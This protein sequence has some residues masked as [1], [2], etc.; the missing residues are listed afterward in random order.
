LEFFKIRNKPLAPFVANRI[1]QTQAALE[2]GANDPLISTEIIAKCDSQRVDPNMFKPHFKQAYQLAL[3]KW[4]KHIQHH[5][6]LPLF[7]DI[8]CFDPRFIRMQINRQNIISYT[9]IVEFQNP[10]NV[11]LDEWSIYCRMEETIEEGEL[12]LDKYWNEKSTILPN[13]SKIALIYIWLPVAGV[14]VERSFS[15]YKSIL[16]ERR[17]RL[18]EK[19]ISMLNF[20]YH[21]QN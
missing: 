1:N 18:S 9:N 3:D 12:D 15:N 20:L 4:N 10:A 19:S 6:A 7:R 11:L 16:S 13:L 8:Q 2:Y 17:M 5:S 21:N 14:D